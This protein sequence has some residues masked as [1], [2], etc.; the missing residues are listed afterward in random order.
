MKK[1][2]AFTLDEICSY[3][4]QD[5]PDK[6]EKIRFQ[7][8]GFRCYGAGERGMGGLSRTANFENDHGNCQ[9]TGRRIKK[10]EV[11]KN[12]WKRK[13]ISNESIEFTGKSIC[14]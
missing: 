11:G 2:K 13:Q 4:K 1:I 5:R 12:V 14:R 10:S 3:L 9:K 7:R 6:A 8:E